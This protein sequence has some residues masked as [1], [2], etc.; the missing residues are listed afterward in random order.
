MEDVV[1]KRVVYKDDR[2]EVQDWGRGT[3][4]DAVEF[5]ASPKWPAKRTDSFIAVDDWG[6]RNIVAATPDLSTWIG[7]SIVQFKNE[8]R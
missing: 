5:C 3:L 8:A 7:K 1:V 6:H 4:Q 2:T